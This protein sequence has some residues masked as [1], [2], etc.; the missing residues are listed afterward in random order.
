MQRSVNRKGIS[1]M[2]QFIAAIRDKVERD[3]I[4][5]SQ[6]AKDAGVGRAYLYR[7]LDGI[8]VPSIERAERIA[9]AAGLK[10]S[11]ENTR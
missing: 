5:M 4:S 6:L 10:L 11:I 2:D 3:K 1:F 8:Q 7:V 9:K